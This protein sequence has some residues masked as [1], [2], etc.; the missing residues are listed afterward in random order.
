MVDLYFLVFIHLG[1]RRIWVSPCTANPTG[2]W[3]TQQARN[4]DMFLQDENLPCT[5]LQRDQD[6]KYVQ[7]FD[8]VFIGEGRKIKKTCPRSPNL[9]AFVP[10]WPRR[11]LY[12]SAP[13]RR[14]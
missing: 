6:T 4:F 14:M 1:T 8:D 13:P 11:W 5:I 2:E 10:E 9:Q 12:Q 3:T 7:A